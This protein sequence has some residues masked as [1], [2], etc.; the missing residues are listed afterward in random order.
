MKV[1]PRDKVLLFVLLLCGG[2][3]CFYNYVFAPLEERVDTLQT[4]KVDIQGFASDVAPLLD[5]AK[6]LKEEKDRL[7]T[8]VENIRTLAQDSTATNEEFLLF[9]GEKTAENQVAVTGFNELGTEHENGIYKT[10][11]DFEL[12]G[13][14]VDINKVLE[15]I[16]NMGIKYSVGSYSFRQDE[17][18]DYLKRFYDDMTKFPWYKE[19]EES[20]T[21]TSQPQSSQPDATTTTQPDTKQEQT[22]AVPA[23]TPSPTP[24]PKPTPEPTLEPELTPVPTPEPELKP[25]PVPGKPAEE[26]PDMAPEPPAEEKEADINDRLQDL[27]E[28]TSYRD[29][30]YHVTLLAGTK[31]AEYKAGQKM[32][33][34][35]TVCLVMFREPSEETSFYHRLT[36]NG[37]DEIL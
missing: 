24:T 6:K 22:E 11:F 13:N 3:S 20:E 35:V 8:G 18:F 19:P 36:R 9:L 30:G 14:T 2:L 26:V 23:P 29:S 1:T 4:V 25:T 17:T 33:L 27:L 32:R 7:K 28:Q 31:K 12:K 5:Q 15:D 10:Y 21:K 16:D 37:A 34:A